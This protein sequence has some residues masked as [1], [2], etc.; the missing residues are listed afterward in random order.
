LGH[1]RLDRTMTAAVIH[2]TPLARHAPDCPAIKD[3]ANLAAR[4]AHYRNE[5][6]ES[7]AGRQALKQIL[8]TPT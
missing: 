8:P 3:I 5:N 4:V 1:V 7:I 6:L 2:Q